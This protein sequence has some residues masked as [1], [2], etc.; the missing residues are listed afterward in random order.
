MFISNYK[1][2]KKSGLFDETYYLTT[3][4]DVRKLDIDP[5][6]HYIKYGWTERRNPSERFDTNFYLDSYSDVKDAGINPLVHFIRYGSKERRRT[7]SEN[8]IVVVHKISKIRKLITIAKH[9][10]NN[11]HLIKKTLRSLKKNGFKSTIIKIM[12]KS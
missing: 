11:P 6:K 12:H 8:S 4:E 9:G 5:I 10:K 1:L 2:I 3:Y 7:H